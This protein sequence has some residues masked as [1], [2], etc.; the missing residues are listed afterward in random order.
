MLRFCCSVHNYPEQKGWASGS[1]PCIAKIRSLQIIKEKRTYHLVA[2]SFHLWDVCG[3]NHTRKSF[4]ILCMVLMLRTVENIQ[5]DHLVCYSGDKNGR[6]THAAKIKAPPKLTLKTHAMNS[7]MGS[8]SV[9]S[10]SPIPNPIPKFD[11]LQ[12]NSPFWTKVS[13][14]PW[15]GKALQGLLADQWAHHCTHRSAELPRRLPLCGQSSQ[16]PYLLLSD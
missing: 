9:L 12:L 4:L 1:K 7:E 11:T 15:M 16:L 6:A 2:F 13:V 8:S 5:S 10:L 14:R 3:R